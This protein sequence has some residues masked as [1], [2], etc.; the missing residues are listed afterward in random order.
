MLT[1][2]VISNIAQAVLL[3]IA[4]LGGG[5]PTQAQIEKTI[6]DELV[7]ASDDD[8]AAEFPGQSA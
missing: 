1:A 4:D 2:E 3:L 8:I 6:T 7:K 5:A